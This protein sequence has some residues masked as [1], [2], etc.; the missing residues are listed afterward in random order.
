MI[1]RCALWPVAGPWLTAACRAASAAATEPHQTLTSPDLH[2]SQFFHMAIRYEGLFFKVSLPLHCGYKMWIYRNVSQTGPQGLPGALQM[3]PE[4]LE[5]I[6]DCFKLNIL[7][8]LTFTLHLFKW[9]SVITIFNSLFIS[10]QNLSYKGLVYPV[11][12][13]DVCVGLN[14]YVS[15]ER[16]IH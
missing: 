16:F 3:V 10:L 9:E 12:Q 11:L 14:I 5:E 13:N 1:R 6:K 8:L 2:S 15:L 4:Q 7:H